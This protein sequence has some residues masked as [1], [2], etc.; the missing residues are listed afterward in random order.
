MTSAQ[1]VHI[2]HSGGAHHQTTVFVHVGRSYSFVNEILGTNWPEHV[3]CYRDREYI[4]DRPSRSIN[5]H[6]LGV[7]EVSGIVSQAARQ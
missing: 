3:F 6:P 7:C 4:A 5:R 2:Q 1:S